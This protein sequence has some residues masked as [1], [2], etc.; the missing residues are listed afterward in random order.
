MRHAKKFCL[1]AVT[2]VLLSGCAT[3]TVSDASDLSRYAP[4]ASERLTPFQSKAT[5]R[6]WLAD[7]ERL[8]NKRREVRRAE[9]KRK[10][11][12]RERRRAELGEDYIA[13]VDEYDEIVVTGSRQAS[14]PNITNV[15]NMGVDEGDIVK[16]VGDHLVLMQDGRL[17]SLSIGDAT[18]SLTARVDIYDEVGE[19]IWYD[20]L[21]VSGRRLVVTGYHYG[22]NATEISVFDLDDTGQFKRQGKWYLDSQDY[23]SDNNSA[24]RMIGD[25]LIFHTQTNVSDPDDFPLLRRK[26]QNR[27]GSILR[28]TD[29]YPPLMPIEYPSLHTVTEC[30]LNQNLDCKSRAVMAP[31]R[32]EWIVTEED[33]FLWVAAPRPNLY[34]SRK[35]ESSE[36]ET[37]AT[38]YRFPIGTDRVEAVTL[39][40]SLRSRFAFEARDDKV[41]ALV[42]QKAEAE[43]FE[44]AELALMDMP[45]SEFSTRPVQVTSAN[46]TPLPGEESYGMKMRYTAD[47]LIYSNFDDD[48]DP[49][50]YV[51]DLNTQ[52]SPV[53]VDAPH[54]IYRLDRVGGN[55][56]LIGSGSEYLGL[57]WLDLS[58]A[59]TLTNTLKL[60]NRFESEGRAQALNMR[61]D[62]DGS[63]LLGLPTYFDGEDPYGND[64]DEEDG[65][66][67]SFAR[68]SSFGQLTNLGPAHGDPSRVDPDYKCE[69]SCVDWY[70]NA[71]PF[72][73][74]DRIFALIASELIELEET[75]GGLIERSRV[76]LSSPPQP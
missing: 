38:L 2:A 27:A 16:Q 56:V 36:R 55:A 52:L 66:D 40:A 9:R 12:E 75:F 34:M 71:R 14:G 6:K 62:T 42:G 8:E 4:L 10:L 32:A 76:N 35:F 25:T 30:K 23:Y 7:S 11:A 67:I 37:L 15:Q 5:Y 31:S 48:D 22:K 60:P 63:A 69:T 50:A 18:P 13:D 29:I 21:L 46:F 28:A 51:I 70:G 26:D 45:M 64:F 1:A 19:D 61:V 58:G 72:F 17:F 47:H 41:L 44:D 49:V 3:Q 39:N 53:K 20:E 54:D 43:G 73:I 59:P 24:T 74:G 57:S 68:V 65:T 33:G